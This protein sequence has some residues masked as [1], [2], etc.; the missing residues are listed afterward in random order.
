MEDGVNDEA[1]DELEKLAVTAEKEDSEPVEKEPVDTD[2]SEVSLTSVDCG[3]SVM[4]LIDASIG[5]IE[6]RVSWSDDEIEK[7]AKLF[8][9]VLDKYDLAESKVL[10]S[11]DEI[12]LLMHMGRLMVKTFKE[13]KALYAVN[14][15]ASSDAPASDEVESATAENLKPMVL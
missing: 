7:G 1:G 5:L 12:T 9:P 15:D 6:P 14:V 13:I 11:S 8:A 4:N 2:K 3:R 10:K